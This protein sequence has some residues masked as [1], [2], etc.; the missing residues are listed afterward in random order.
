M[1]YAALAPLY[2]HA[3]F[4]I[5]GVALRRRM[6][7]K[8]EKREREQ[9]GS[10]ARACQENAKTVVAL[11]RLLA[12]PPPCHI[13]LHRHCSAM[14]NFFRSMGRSSRP[15]KSPT[16]PSMPYDTAMGTAPGTTLGAGNKPL[17]LCNPFVRSALI[18][19]SFRTIVVLPKYVDQKEWI[20]VNREFSVP[21]V[22]C[23]ADVD[24]TAMLH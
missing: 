4:D 18:K 19:G 2:I 23:L 3:T 21:V 14:S 5:D 24:L 10:E 6:R 16:M 7:V 17:Y 1:P 9:S 12:S 20:A 11:S 22:S 15:K 8:G 13:L